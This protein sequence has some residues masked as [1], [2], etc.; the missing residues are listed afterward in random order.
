MAADLILC[1]TNIIVDVLRGNDSI[2]G[3]LR[4]IGEENL[5]VSTITIGELYWG[6]RNKTE[7]TKTMN[8]IKALN[9]LPVNEEISS[10]FLSISQKYCLSHNIGIPDSFIA[11]T[12]IFYSVK[13]FTLNKKDFSFI[14]GINLY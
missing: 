10:I 1:D 9:H 4:Q 11:A 12:S 2:I 5:A 14:D 8:A 13:L 3:T 6:A 7:L